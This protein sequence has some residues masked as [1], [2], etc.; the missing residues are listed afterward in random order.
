MRTTAQ[1]VDWLP[2]L[3][4]A[5]NGASLLGQ[6]RYFQL[7]RADLALL[8]IG[9]ALAAPDIHNEAAAR[10]VRTSA[11]LV[12]TVGLFVALAVHLR[13]DRQRWYGG[14]AAAESIKSLAWRYM[15]CAQPFELSRPAGEVDREFASALQA[16]LAQSEQLA[17][18]LMMISDGPQITERMRNV[19]ALDL[20]GRMQAYLEE[21]VREQQRWYS[22]KAQVNAQRERL[23]TVLIIAAHAV[24][25]LFA[26]FLVF[27]PT[28]P[29]NA[30]G[31]FATMAAAFLAWLQAREHQGLAQAYAV[32]AHELGLVE[33]Q[34]LHVASE[35]AFATFVADAEGAISREHTLWVARRDRLPRHLLGASRS[36]NAS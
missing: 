20:P 33:A 15:T 36:S 3:H 22:S 18:P 1:S 14:R 29:L 28:A 19:R 5:A 10:V 4:G 30:T 31:V 34:A 21:R 8:V 13:Q 25:L 24:A 17:L 11:A 32:T 35:E 2:A 12:L 16:I 23:F 9:A 27:R 6:R 26:V 7:I